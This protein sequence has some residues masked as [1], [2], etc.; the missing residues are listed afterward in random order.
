[1]KHFFFSSSFSQG[2]CFRCLLQ[3]SIHP[4]PSSSPPPPPSQHTRLHTVNHTPDEPHDATRHFLKQGQQSF[5]E[6]QQRR[7]GVEIVQRKR[8]SLAVVHGHHPMA[9]R[10]KD[11]TV[12][13]RDA[14]ESS[15]GAILPLEVG[16]RHP[17]V[18]GE[19]R[20]SGEVEAHIGAAW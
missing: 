12:A 17:R 7:R 9:G 2:P 8:Q 5:S 10:T 19:G 1:M 16:R 4:L 15:S 20:A 3:E 11:P 14:E 13:D 18:V 6:S